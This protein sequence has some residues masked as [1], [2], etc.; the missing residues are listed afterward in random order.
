[1]AKRVPPDREEYRPVNEQLVRAALHRNGPNDEDDGQPRA[2][3]VE[4]QPVVA[5][6]ADETPRSAP[7]ER[8][9]DS[10]RRTAHR[11]ATPFER[12]ADSG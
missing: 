10:R 5:Q 6:Q 4:P 2:A 1:M 9:E 7:P 12:G 11:Q 8:V 3:I